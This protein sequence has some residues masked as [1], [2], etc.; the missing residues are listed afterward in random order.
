VTRTLLGVGVDPAS[1]P[2]GGALPPGPQ[3]GGWLAYGSRAMP[4]RFARYGG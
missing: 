2:A 3:R 4:R 1:L